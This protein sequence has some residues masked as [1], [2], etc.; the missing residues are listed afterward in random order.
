[1]NKP[2]SVDSRSL[3][4]PI[5]LRYKQNALSIEYSPL[6]YASL[7]EVKY[8]MAGLDEDWQISSNYRAVY[9]YL[10][11]GE[12]TFMLFA[13]DMEGEIENMSSILIQVASPFWATWWF[14]SLAALTILGFLYWFD[15]ERLKRKEAVYAMRLEIATKLHKEIEVA[16]N[17]INILSEIARIK[18]KD[19]SSKANEYIEQI[20]AKSQNMIIAMDDML[21]AIR[22]ENDRIYK[23]IE[24]FKEYVDTLK[25]HPETYIDLLIS[26]KIEGQ[27]LDMKQRQMTLRLFKEGVNN[28]LKCG[29]NHCQIFITIEKTQL[30]YTIDFDSTQLDSQ[31]L[32]NLLQREELS[33]SL[34]S[35]SGIITLDSQRSKSNLI[36]KIPL[37]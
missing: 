37:A 36:L 2:I 19:Y 4:S 16:L 26:S 12:Y 7:H 6:T 32:N 17:S 20:N 11:P 33:A 30:L 29:G 5:Q 8:K 10:P 21:W 13:N 14:Y 35:I 22:P 28:V 34:K 15:T 25:N 3:T 18:S 1:M 27:K 24:R 9:S 23:V 31:R